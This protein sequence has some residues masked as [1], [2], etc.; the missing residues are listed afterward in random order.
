MKLAIT[1]IIAASIVAAAA[2]TTRSDSASQPPAR[3]Q[4]VRGQA[5]PQPDASLF[6]PSS[7]ATLH[8]APQG[9]EIGTLSSTAVVAVLARERGWARVRAEGWIAEE[10]L[11]PADSTLRHSPG[12]ADIR[13]DPAGMRGR[14]VRWDV[15]FISFLQA[16]P[17]RRDM[18]PEEWYILARGPVGE[19]AVVY[20][21]VPPSLTSTAQSLSPLSRITVTARVR[22]GRSQPAGVPLL[23]L[24]SLVRR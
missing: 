10:K 8:S 24:E 3:G 16:D 13:A 17:L 21:V 22:L 4:P 15:E 1:T 9:A 20:L 18:A 23:D 19:N 14:L 12:A 2:L 11:V 5:V 6:S 7:S